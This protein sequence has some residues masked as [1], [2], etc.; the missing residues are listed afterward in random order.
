MS[1]YII[2]Y[3]H[4]NEYNILCDQQHG[5]H[6]GCSCETELLLTFNDYAENLNRN[7]QTDVIFLDF[8][9]AFDK[10]S[11]TPAFVS[12]HYGIRG[13]ILDWIQHF[14]LQRS[15]RVDGEGQQSESSRATSGVPHGTVLAP[16]LFLC[17]IDDLADGVLSK[18]KLY[19]DGF[20]LCF[21]SHRTGLSTTTERS[22]H[23]INGLK[24]GRWYI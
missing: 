15:Q 16:L 9:K 11:I 21:Y 1:N 2:I 3:A 13:N 19:A 4:L 17:F 24:N 18:V 7:E 23:P 20:T 14:V 12:H 22:G 10:V 6:Q 5:F 8:L